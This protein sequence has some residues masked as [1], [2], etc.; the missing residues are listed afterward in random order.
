MLPSLFTTGAF[1]KVNAGLLVLGTGGGRFVLTPAFEVDLPRGDS[2]P[3]SVMSR[4]DD[5]LE[6]VLTPVGGRLVARAREEGV[7]M[8]DTSTVGARVRGGGRG[9]G[10]TSL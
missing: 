4:A 3:G 6:R 2:M 5:E 1:L 8:V 10:L 9:R 7:G